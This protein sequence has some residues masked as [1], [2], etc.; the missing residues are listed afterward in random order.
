[1][2]IEGSANIEGETLNERDSIEISEAKSINIE[3]SKDTKLLLI[4]TVM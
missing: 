3:V 2:V 1:M 4:D